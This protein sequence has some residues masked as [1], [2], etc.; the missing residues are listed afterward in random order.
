MKT[1][2][3]LSGFD[4]TNGAGITVDIHTALLLNIYPV[5]VPSVLTI[6][7]SLNFYS[8]KPVDSRYIINS[9]NSI[10]EEFSPDILKIGLIPTENEKWLKEIESI[11]QKFKTIIIDPILKPFSA[12][13]FFQPSKFFIKFISGNNKILTPNKKELIKLFELIEKKPPQN[14]SISEIAQIIHNKTN[15]TLIVKFER[16]KGK[17]LILKN[18]KETVLYF[19]LKNISGEIHGTGCRFSTVIACELEKKE[20]LINAVQNAINFMD[21]KLDNIHKF[22]NKGQF[23]IV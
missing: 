16:E 2:A 15:A 1:I 5:S 18:Q 14:L 12:N 22:S 19:D 21:K 8:A 17:V 3:I 4:P 13:N 6:Q 10:F 20:S 11:F 7:N 9:F 23:F